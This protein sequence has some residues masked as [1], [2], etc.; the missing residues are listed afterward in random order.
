MVAWTLKRK[1]QRQSKVLCHWSLLPWVH[2]L[3][4]PL[5]FRRKEGKSAKLVLREGKA[6]KCSNE[7]V[8]VF[9]FRFHIFPW[10]SEGIDFLPNY[11]I[12]LLAFLLVCAYALLLSNLF[13]GFFRA[14]ALTLFDLFPRLC[15]PHFMV[16]IL[17]STVLSLRK[18]NSPSPF[19]P[20]SPL[21]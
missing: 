14:T 13:P 9:L 2:V 1:L 8:P 3:W 12:Y 10:V 11:P 5:G 7:G 17:A 15:S 4:G 18:K 19:S 21:S 16:T 6:P 20:P